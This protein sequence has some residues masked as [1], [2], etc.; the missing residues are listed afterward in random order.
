VR[1]NFAHA[2]AAPSEERA[3][4]IETWAAIGDDEKAA[5]RFMR[6]HPALWHVVPPRD[7]SCEEREDSA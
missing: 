4:L 2:L 7:F 5:F 1:R 6:Q 3:K